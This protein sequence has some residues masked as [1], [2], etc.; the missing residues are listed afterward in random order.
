MGRQRTA[1]GERQRFEHESASSDAATAAGLAC[2]SRPYSRTSTGTRKKSGGACEPTVTFVL[3]QP[4]NCGTRSPQINRW[5][6][7]R[8]ESSRVAF[9]N[10][11]SSIRRSGARTLCARCRARSAQ[12]RTPRRVSMY[13]WR[14][15][16]RE[17]R[18]QHRQLH[19]FPLECHTLG[20]VHRNPAAADTGLLQ[21]GEGAPALGR[22]FPVHERHYRFRC[23]KT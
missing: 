2:R 21:P 5:N 23:W 8:S 18:L 19:R 22:L 3:R 17:F 12:L 15:E 4:A 10:S 16:A 9:R 1:F 13:R 7:R 20:Y 11:P 14:V 6:S